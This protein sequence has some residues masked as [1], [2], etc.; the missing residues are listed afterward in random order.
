M[1][2][3]ESLDIL[4]GLD[5]FALTVFGP[6]LYA[7][8]GTGSYHWL[9]PVLAQC[10]HVEWAGFAVWDMIMP[11]FMFMSGVAIPFAFSKYIDGTKK[12]KEA[13]LR[14]LRRVIVLWVFGMIYQGHLLDLNIGTLKLFTNT[15]Q[16]IAV[17]YLFAAVI[18]MNT[19]PRTQIGIVASLLILYWALMMSVRVGSYGGGDFTPDGNLCEYIDRVVMGRWRDHATVNSAG[20]VT[21]ADSYRYTWILSSLGFIATTMTGTLAGVILKSDDSDRKKMLTLLV[22]GVAM[23]AAG[24]LWHLQMPVIKKIWT[25]SMVLVTSGYSF[26]LI[27]LFYYIVD[28]RGWKKGL[29]WLKIYGM[30]SIVAYMIVKVSFKSIGQSLLYGLEQYVGEAWYNLVLV[31]FNVIIVFFILRYLY[32]HKI[33]LKV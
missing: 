15:L 23:V 1:K 27:L 32:K 9:E 6:I 20:I 14:I 16:S 11:L 25:S 21:F 17:G 24:W 28:Y 29:Q 10:D 5:L 18:F 2:R 8:A 26:L 19:K 12:R 22:A 31:L 4:R 30:N 13:Y 3:L 7:F 33:F